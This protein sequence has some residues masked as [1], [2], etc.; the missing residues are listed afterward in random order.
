MSRWSMASCIATERLG[1]FAAATDGFLRL[2]DAINPV[3]DF[4]CPRRSS[5]RRHSFD[6]R[7]PAVM[8]YVPGN[9]WT[10]RCGRA[11]RQR[12]CPDRDRA[13]EGRVI[14]AWP[15][16]TW[17]D[18]V[19]IEDCRGIFR[20]RNSMPVAPIAWATCTATAIS[21]RFRTRSTLS[22]AAAKSACL[23]A[24][25]MKTLPLTGARASPSA[26]AARDLI[27]SRRSAAPSSI[28]R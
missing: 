21:L 23:P 15:E 27:R 11:D 5:C 28:A 7:R 25:L 9:Y 8:S 12:A 17:G 13:P 26:V 16:I 24:S 14:I 2:W 18:P 6:L 4:T 19:E 20:S 22:G 3:S 10:F 1:S